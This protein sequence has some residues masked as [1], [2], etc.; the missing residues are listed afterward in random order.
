[1]H[2]CP[3]HHGLGI[4]LVP[5]G[6]NLRHRVNPREDYLTPGSV[7]QTDETGR[8]VMSLNTDY[9][10]GRSALTILLPTTVVKGSA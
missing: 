8:P 7:P 9:P 6:Q 1:M 4:R 2:D 3:G 10:D 5:A